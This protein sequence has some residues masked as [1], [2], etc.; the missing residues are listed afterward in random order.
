MKC[1]DPACHRRAEVSVH[2]DGLVVV[3]CLSDGIRAARELRGRLRLLG[4]RAEVTIT[5]RGA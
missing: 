3:A 2:V 5:E 1:A 4:S